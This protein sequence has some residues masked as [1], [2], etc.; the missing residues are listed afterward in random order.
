MRLLP[1][2]TD[3]DKAI[4]CFFITTF[5]KEAPRFSRKIFLGCKTF[6]YH[7]GGEEIDTHFKVD[8]QKIR[9][10]RKMSGINWEIGI[11]VYTLLYTK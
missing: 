4:P 8:A 11:D 7:H 10:S 2:H 5:R 1:F 3:W 9:K 6:T